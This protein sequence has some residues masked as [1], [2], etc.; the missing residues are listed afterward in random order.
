[1]Y[2]MYREACKRD[3]KWVS[4]R[5]ALRPLRAGAIRYQGTMLADFKKMNAVN[6]E[7]IEALFNKDSV[8]IAVLDSGLGGCPSARSWSGLCKRGLFFERYPYFFTVN[9]GENIPDSLYPVIVKPSCESRSIGISDD[10]VVNTPDDLERAINYIHSEFEQ[11]ALVEEYLPGAEYTV[12]MYGNVESQEYLS[13]V[14][15]VEASHYR[16]RLAWFF[17]LLWYQGLL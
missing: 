13:G 2:P 14:V 9:I 6:R 3:K 12:L 7:K 16:K 4:C 1:M 11:P 15:K 5:S 10:S 17:T 8:L